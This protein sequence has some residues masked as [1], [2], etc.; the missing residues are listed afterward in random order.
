MCERRNWQRR[1]DRPRPENRRRATGAPP[2]RLVAPMRAASSRVGPDNAASAAEREVEKKKREHRLPQL[3]MGKVADEVE[4]GGRGS[5]LQMTET[6]LL[7]WR[8]EKA[9]VAK[10]VVAKR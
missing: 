9:L 3:W 1:G 4:V 10:P 2:R 7:G 8:R 6:G 5:R